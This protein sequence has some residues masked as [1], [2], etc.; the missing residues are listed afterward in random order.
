MSRALLIFLSEGKIADRVVE[1]VQMGSPLTAAEK[2]QS[3]SSPTVTW[4]TEMVKKYVG[5]EDTLADRMNWDVSRGR[6]FQHFASMTY[7]C[8]YIDA[9]KTV[10]STVLKKWLESS[11]AVSTCLANLPL[12]QFTR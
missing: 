3:I 1:R 6:P 4:L 5:E 12:T 10:T 7:M 11:A 8:W 9:R 2:L